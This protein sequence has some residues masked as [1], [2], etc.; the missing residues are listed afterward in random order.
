MAP[1]GAML[2]H[3]ALSQLMQQ[4][5]PGHIACA[6]HYALDPSRWPGPDWSGSGPEDDGVRGTR[7]MGRCP[8]RFRAAF[9][10]ALK[11]AFRVAF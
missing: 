10:V 5:L 4:T 7:P 3:Q 8:E 6:M 1:G 11:V 2:M 9:R